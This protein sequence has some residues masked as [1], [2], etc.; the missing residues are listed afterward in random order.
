MS[1]TWIE[2][3]SV[4]AE[5]ILDRVERESLPTNIYRQSWG[6]SYFIQIRHKGKL[7]YLGTY[8]TLEEALEVRDAARRELGR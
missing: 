7:H 8:P 1:S 6:T 2:P 5:H 4:V 3:E